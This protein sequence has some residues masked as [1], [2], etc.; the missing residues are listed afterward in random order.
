MYPSPRL[1]LTAVTL[2]DRKR[3]SSALCDAVARAG[4]FVLD[5][6]RFSNKSITVV[7]EL[8]RDKAAHLA[9]LLQQ[10]EVRLDEPSELSLTNFDASA[11][12]SVDESRGTLSV[13]FVTDEPELRV[14]TPAVPG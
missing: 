6:H 14:T 4:G 1:R 7:F 3:I 5:T 9:Q 10:S 11:P 13:R 12:D 8:P 2:G